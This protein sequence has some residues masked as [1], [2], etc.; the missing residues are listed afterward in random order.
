MYEGSIG[1]IGVL[2]F[3]RSSDSKI[4]KGDKSIVYIEKREISTTIIQG[5]EL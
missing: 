3:I 1:L 4:E 5:R 2:T